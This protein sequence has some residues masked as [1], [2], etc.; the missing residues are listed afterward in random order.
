MNKLKVIVILSFLILPVLIITSCQQSDNPEDKAIIEKTT[1]ADTPDGSFEAPAYPEPQDELIYLVP[2][3]EFHKEEPVN[4][5]IKPPNELPE[6]HRTLEDSNSSYFA[7]ERRITQGENF[8]NGVFE[9]PFTSKD[10]FYRPDLDIIN[11]DFAPGDRY[12]FFTIHLY[13]ENIQE[14][15]LRG[16]YSIEFD[17]DLNKR[18]DLLVT[19]TNPSEEWSMDNVIVYG[20]EK[21]N[22]DNQDQ[23]K[24]DTGFVGNGY[25]VTIEMH[26]VINAFSRIDPEDKNSIQFAISY[27]LI[28]TPERFL[29]GAWADGGLVDPTRY[30][31]NKVMDLAAAGSPY[32]GKDYP[33]KA[34]YNLDNTCKL[35]FGMDQA[36]DYPGMCKIGIPPSVAKTPQAKSPPTIECPKVLRCRISI[37]GFICGW[38]EVCD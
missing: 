17:R 30:S 25:D 1:L 28:G 15:G 6:I 35:P 37:S 5:S 23:A 8:L 19:V 14:G 26:D 11:V 2:T 9:R 16:T 21:R 4:N 12:L 3:Q 38:V 18:G 10:M 31:Y 27:S 7:S 29:W 24:A 13:G 33:L 34:L 22:V 36:G 32:H 20:I